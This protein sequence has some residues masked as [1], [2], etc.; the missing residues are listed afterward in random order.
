MIV[1]SLQDLPLYRGLYQNLDTLI[2]WLA[3]NDPAALDCGRHDIDG[4]RVYANVMEAVTRPE[5]E[6]H[7]ET[8]RRYM[9]LQ[10]DV[11]GREAFKV[12]LGPTTVVQPYDE[13]SDFDLVDAPDGIAG[14]LDRGC[15]AIFMAGEPH[16]P[17]LQF[18]D[19]GERPVKKICFKILVD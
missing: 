17:T 3:D 9:D 7:Y 12:S 4:D 2:D 8:H 15:F 1:G 11:E 14:D 18:P 16:M 10:I 19:D 6:A 5:S 13:E